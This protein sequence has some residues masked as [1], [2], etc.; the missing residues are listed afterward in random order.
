MVKLLEN[1]SL[2]EKS[3]NAPVDGKIAVEIA[4]KIAGKIRR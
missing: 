2:I 1:S 3:T 4:G